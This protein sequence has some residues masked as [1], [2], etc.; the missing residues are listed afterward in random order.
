MKKIIM[1]GIFLPVLFVL[2]GAC[3]SKE[4]DRIT[5]V[6]GN[7]PAFDVQYIRTSYG[8]K[9]PA[10]TIIS[11]VNDLEQYSKNAEYTNATTKYTD[12]YFADNFLLIVF[13]EEPS[14]SNRHKVEK[15][16]ENGDI[17]IHQIIPE[18][19]TSDMAAWNIII[20]LNNSFKLEQFQVV[21]TAAGS[22]VR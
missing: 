5:L 20:E 22:G 3:T 1:S 7:Q 14:G 13:L 2:L 16:G 10:Y 21:L 9:L 8:E 12:E 18:I 6:N 4:S 15:I 19:G 17:V 11:S